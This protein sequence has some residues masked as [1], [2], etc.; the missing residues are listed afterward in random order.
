MIL[1]YTD[2]GLI[3]V[4]NFPP[5]YGLLF[6]TLDDKKTSSK[7]KKTAKLVPKPTWA[8]VVRRW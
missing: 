3:G 5:F 8:I 1:K 4:R 7:G 6:K 2:L